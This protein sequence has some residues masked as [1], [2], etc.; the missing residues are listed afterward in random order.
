M[1]GGKE[2]EELLRDDQRCVG[3]KPAE[4]GVWRSSSILQMLRGELGG[5]S[6]F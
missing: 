6:L 2:E 3:R 4:R 1:T 5:F